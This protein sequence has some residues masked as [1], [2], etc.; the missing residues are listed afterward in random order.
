[1]VVR[2]VWPAD[3]RVGKEFWLPA[4]SAGYPFGLQE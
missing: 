4:N 2:L 3:L 1:V